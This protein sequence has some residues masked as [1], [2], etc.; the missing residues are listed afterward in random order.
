VDPIY[1]F[2]SNITRL[3]NHILST[4]TVLTLAI[5]SATYKERLY[6]VPKSYVQCKMCNLPPY[7]EAQP[8]IIMPIA[9]ATIIL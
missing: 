7:P 6:R 5:R 4:F 3:E 8:I 1:V 2:F 9:A